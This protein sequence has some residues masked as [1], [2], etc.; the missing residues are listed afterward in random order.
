MDGHEGEI[1]GLL[2]K[3]ELRIKGKIVRQGTKKAKVCGS[4]LERE[5]RKLECSISYK[6]DLRCGR[7]GGII[8]W[9]LVRVSQ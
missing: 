3:L 4:K 9:D 6:T 8:F 1:L 7:G 2:E 5:L